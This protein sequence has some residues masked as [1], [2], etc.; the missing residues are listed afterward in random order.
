MLKVRTLEIMNSIKEKRLLAKAKYNA[1]VLH[2][3]NQI[4]YVLYITIARLDNDSSELLVKGLQ[5]LVLK[6]SR[7]KGYYNSPIEDVASTIEKCKKDIEDLK[8]S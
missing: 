6:Y 7:M 2:N 5:V 1:Y 3:N 8:N 4:P